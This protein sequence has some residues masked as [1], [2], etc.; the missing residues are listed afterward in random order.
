M[1]YAGRL[2]GDLARR[3]SRDE[4][5]DEL[6][7]THGL[8]LRLV[9]DLFAAAERAAAED[10]RGRSAV[11][12][13]KQLAGISGAEP[14]S[15][16]GQR[17]RVQAVYGG[18]VPVGRRTGV[19]PGKVSRTMTLAAQ[20]A[21][22]RQRGAAEPLPPSIQAR[23]SDLFGVDF[24]HVMVHADSPEATGSIKAV[25]RGGEIHF[26]DGA[27]QPG[28][29][30]GD[31]L[32]AHELAHLVQ[33][34]GGRAGK[35]EGA[36]REL[37]READVAAALVARGQRARVQLL[38]PTGAYAYNEGE[39]HDVEAGNLDSEGQAEPGGEDD[40]RSRAKRE[41]EREG[42]PESRGTA[43]TG[44]EIERPG[45]SESETPIADPRER[46]STT[47]SEREGENTEADARPE[48][49]VGG[50]TE[51]EPERTADGERETESR[52]DSDQASDAGTGGDESA[53]E[54]GGDL[55]GELQNLGDEPVEAEGG[56]GGAP[57]VGGGGAPARPIKEP[58]SVASAPPESAF[59]QLR[60]VRPDKL[61]SA[62]P[63]LHEAATTDV[64]KERERAKSNPPRQMSTGEIAQGRK[65]ARAGQP[66][67]G[68]DNGR[69][70][71]APKDDA[72]KPVKADLPGD[73]SAKQAKQAEATA[74]QKAAGQAVQGVAQSAVSSFRSI[75][76]GSGS[77]GKG[78]PMSEADA[79][80]MAGA[81][82]RMSADVSS[83]D[84]DPGPP[85]T[86]EMKGEAK[87]STDRD[88]AE[89]ERKTTAAE[90]QAMSDS[91][92]PMGEDEIETTVAPEELTAQ[93]E[94]GQVPEVALPTVAGKASSEEIGIIAQEQHQA[95]I[96]A[97]LGKAGGDVAGERAKQDQAEMQ[98]RAD[99]DGQIRQ[100]KTQADGEQE[101]A[102]RIAKTE[103]DQ[104]RGTWQAEVDKKGSDARS[105]A[106]RKVGEGVA[107][108]EAEESKANQEARQHIDEGKKK[109]DDE[110]QRGEREA[111][112][113]KKKG[114]EKSSGFWGWVKSKAKAL[115]DSIKKAISAVIDA[116]R[117]AVRVVIDAAKKLAM[118]AIE[119]ARKAIVA[120]IEAVGKALLAITDVLLA[121]F[122]ELKAKF[123]KAI[124]GMVDKAVN[125]VNKLA[126]G[127]KK[128]VQKA[129]DLLGAAL[130]RALG[131]L[132]KAL[133]AIVDAVG[134]VIEAAIKAAEAIAAALGVWA[135]LIKDVATSPGSW[136][137]KLGVA[138]VD[139]IKNHLWIALKSAVIDWFHSK[140]FELLGIGGLILQVLLDGGITT[141]DI[142]DMAI[143]ALI[144]AIPVILVTILIEKMV[145]M[146][147]PAA[148]AVMAI[149][150]GLIAA[151][152]TVSRIIAAFAA[153]V[154]FLL[155]VKG[156][157]AGPLF[158]GL[159]AAAAVVVLDFIANWL[160]RK[161]A[162]PARKVGKRLEKMAEKFKAK[163]KGKGKPNGKNPAD[164]RRRE[165]DEHGARPPPR[166][167]R[168]DHAPGPPKKHADND[169][170][171]G[172][173]KSDSDR[174]AEKD[175]EN[176]DR[177]D[178]AIRALQPKV[179]SLLK[180]GAS[181][182]R[183]RAQL[184]VWRAQYR[185]TALQVEGP[186]NQPRIIAK[187]NPEGEVQKG[188][189]LTRDE[190]LKLARNVAAR[191]VIR[192][193]SAVP[194]AVQRQLENETPRRGKRSDH[195]VGIM[196]DGTPLTAREYQ[197]QGH[198]N[199]MVYGELDGKRMDIGSYEKIH[200]TIRSTGM[201][202]AEFARDMTELIKTGAVP[203]A[204]ASNPRTAAFSG[205]LKKLM[206]R[207]ATRNPMA[208]LTAP[209]GLE[210]VASGSLTFEEL[211]TGKPVHDQHRPPRDQRGGGGTDPMSMKGA[212][213]AA[214]TTYDQ[215]G[216]EFPV[217]DPEKQEKRRGTPE[218]AEE[219]QEREKDM[220]L[221]WL[222]EKMGREN[223]VF[224]DKQTAQLAVTRILIDLCREW[225]GR[226]L[227]P[228]I[229]PRR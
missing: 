110:K 99:T 90:T 229:R 221:R 156:G 174:K 137:S 187:V 27:Y 177:L 107:Q 2:D 85:P 151:W 76:K 115:V 161:L 86:L 172:K 81:I 8:D 130:D 92:V 102:R 108:V 132:E 207:E 114:E 169:G 19:S 143:Q 4:L 126:E 3:A 196:P 37:E 144:V 1:G 67:G 84:T 146:I 123:Q 68:E 145:S 225:Y 113:A 98:A 220:L 118:A 129:L 160:L 166:K 205:A 188:L 21:G 131:L 33:Q 82:D 175:R 176:R 44:R 87:D 191:E 193:Q 24:S 157:G 78:D 80:Q 153:F 10:P 199:A 217:L 26:R 61:T 23:M 152:G 227:A 116:V 180:R 11:V 228:P 163:R 59:G 190:L 150:E 128:A 186:Q 165:D 83:V 136:I 178:K 28:T 109:A 45:G 56:G 197:Q 215:L 189:C 75:D 32:I 121:A 57:N 71:G 139:G 185:L 22:A 31:Q 195:E 119:L 69:A 104:A 93:P 25:A 51:S 9:Q 74:Q 15:A 216:L 140:V 200:S 167:D 65:G 62:L 111:E 48:R 214:R 173:K 73:Q 70:E 149:V 124:R 226:K 141:N 29:P 34:E 159:L 210:M 41:A 6:T 50:Q 179:A 106:D 127:L 53:G 103:V 181:K 155:A 184:L 135:K 91:R 43:E 47:Q 112:E 203:A 7:A 206:D 194:M 89:L 105:Q 122:P 101:G 30:E 201:S 64:G 168:D 170:P 133:H 213:R 192:R 171:D 16:P 142:T 72:D 20:I 54:K 224:N 202:D 63:D 40:E 208:L 117:K 49:E 60:G 182:Y 17:T 138:V 219:L 52:A 94:S 100:L 120:V 18:A 134:A 79:Q 211:Y 158:A 212:P 154:A 66:E 13:F 55:R 12:W 162:G 5:I 97:A 198:T 38:A 35:R 14:T 164:K 147:V 58:P 223:L 125:A 36:R 209:M 222:N 218:E 88:R 46:E 95:D 39:D 148:G 77:A 42:E 96:D 204:L 183:L